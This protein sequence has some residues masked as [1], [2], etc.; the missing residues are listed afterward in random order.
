MTQLNKGAESFTAAN[1][2]DATGFATD[3]VLAIGV[4]FGR[5]GAGLDQSALATNGIESLDITAGAEGIIGGA[6][7][8]ELI[9]DVNSSADA[10]VRNAGKVDL[11]IKA[12][13]LASKVNNMHT[14]HSRARSRL[15]GGE[16]EYTSISSGRMSATGDTLIDDLVV[17]GGTAKINKGSAAAIARVKQTGGK[18]HL[19]RQATAIIVGAGAVLDLDPDDGVTWTGT[20]IQI[21]GGLVRWWGG[22]LP[23]IEA[24]GGEIDFRPA[25]GPI[26]GLGSTKFEVAGTVIRSTPDIDMSNLV[27]LGAI[28]RTEVSPLDGYSAGF[29]PVPE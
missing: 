14:G 29:A 1:W 7:E 20:T 15:R 9:V 25:R 12:G 6:D 19:K 22:A 21:F 27:N 18:L 8:G 28:Y 4:T 26:T 2:A 16:F 24:Y 11:Y 13:T 23:S 5:I 3:A 17:M 10:R